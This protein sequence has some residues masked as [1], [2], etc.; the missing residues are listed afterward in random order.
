[1]LHSLAMD[2]CDWADAPSIPLV[3]TNAFSDRLGQ[4]LFV[5]ITIDFDAVK[6]LE[7]F[8]HLAVDWSDVFSLGGCK[9]KTLACEVT[10]YCTQKLN[11]F[12]SVHTRQHHPIVQ[13]DLYIWSCFGR[14]SWRG[15]IIDHKA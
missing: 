2:C 12:A 4:R 1:M 6:L 3:E 10:A 14:A 11:L 5:E 9:L 7:G 13:A 15:L 8:K